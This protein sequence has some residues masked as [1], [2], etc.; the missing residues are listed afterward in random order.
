MGAVNS[1]PTASWNSEYIPQAA[2]IELFPAPL[3]LY[4]SFFFSSQVVLEEQFNNIAKR[5]MQKF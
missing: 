4:N 5:N 1:F 3:W 2:L